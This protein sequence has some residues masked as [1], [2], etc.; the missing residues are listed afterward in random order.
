[1]RSRS[2]TRAV[3]AKQ[4]RTHAR[5][6][7]SS[8]ARAQALQAVV[9]IRTREPPHSQLRSGGVRGCSCEQVFALRA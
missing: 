4:V 8:R 1:M 5:A 7:A 2:Q 3:A 6:R 9:H